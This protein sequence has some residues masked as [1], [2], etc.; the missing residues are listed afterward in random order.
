MLKHHAITHGM[1]ETSE[2]RSWAEMKSRCLNPKSRRFSYY[3]GRGITVCERWL[4]FQNFIDDMGNKPTP[5]HSIERI[6]VNGNY[7]PSNCK[8]V[9]FTEQQ[10]NKRN[11]TMI[12][13]NGKTQSIKD[14]CRELEL[15]YRTIKDRL[16]NG[17]TV[18]EMFETPKMKSRWERK[19][20]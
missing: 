16:I 12:E 11:T 5:E 17:W 13:Y 1:S 10:N 8:W 19:V 6:D 2:Y 4:D 15:N 7:E 18:K 3:G 9:T 20:K 14:W